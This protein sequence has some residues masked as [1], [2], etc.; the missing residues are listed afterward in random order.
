MGIDKTIRDRRPRDWAYRAAFA[1]E[2]LPAL[3]EMIKHIRITHDTDMI[4]DF[5]SKCEEKLQ[6]GNSVIIMDD[7]EIKAVTKTE[8]LVVNDGLEQCISIILSNA[9]RWSYM[10]VSK[11]NGSIP[12]DINNTTLDNSGGGPWELSLD[13]YVWAEPRGMK[14][15]F[16]C[17]GPQDTEG[18]LGTSSINEMAIGNGSANFPSSIM[19]NREIFPYNTLERDYSDDLQVYKYVFIFSS[20]IEFCPVA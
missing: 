11:G 8:D 17:I 7:V 15:F 1:R 18:D 9:T 12:L 13:K 4:E 16:G 14:L 10:H 3:Q 20:V 2:D 6:T 19:L 5:N